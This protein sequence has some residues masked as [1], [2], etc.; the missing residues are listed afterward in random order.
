MPKNVEIL[1]TFTSLTLTTKILIIEKSS[2]AIIHEK[3]H[4]V[5]VKSPFASQ[6]R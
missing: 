1:S 3:S 6:K 4:F 5:N 2:S